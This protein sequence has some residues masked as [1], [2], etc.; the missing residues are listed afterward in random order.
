M[1]KV[2][3]VTPRGLYKVL[4]VEILNVETTEGQIGILANHMPIVAMLTISSMTTNESNGRHSYAISGGTVYFQNNNATVLA[5]TIEHS[6][7]IDLD[8]A[9][10]ARVRAETLLSASQGVDTN[11]AEVALKRAINRI[12]TAA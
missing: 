9:E 10:E 2:R 8:R 5:N 11:R 3:I 1:F 12:K 7:E 4:E 6:D